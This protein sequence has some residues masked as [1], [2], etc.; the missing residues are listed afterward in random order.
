MTIGK[1]TAPSPFAPGAKLLIP[2]FLAVVLVIVY[3]PVLTSDFVNYDDPTYVTA[4]S[5]VRQGIRLGAIL[6][7][8][9][10]TVGGFWQ[11]VTVLS[12][13]LDATLFG[14]NPAG[15]HLTSLLIHILNIL[16]LF[17]LLT[18]LTGSAWRSGLV[19]AL[20]ALHPLNVETVAWVAERKSLLCMLFWLLCLHSYLGYTRTF[21]IGRYLLTFLFFI[22]SLMSKPMGITIPFTMLL[23]DYWPLRR[24]AR[25][26]QGYTDN[27]RWMVLEKLPFFSLSVAFVFLTMA[28]QKSNG[29]ILPS[30]H[31]PYVLLTHVVFNYARYI[32]KMVNPTHLAVLYPRIAG[33]LSLNEIMLSLVALVLISSL[34]LRGLKDN[35]YLLTG[36]LWFLLTLLPVV[37]FVTVGYFDIAD[38]FAYVPLI[39]LFIALSWGLG[40]LIRESKR[41]SY[42]TAAI[43]LGL[44]LL[45]GFLT[46]IQAGYWKNGYTLFDHA[47]QTTRGNY[48][49]HENL[50]RELIAMGRF[51]EAI[52][53]LVESVRIMPAYPNARINLGLTLYKTGRRADGI[54]VLTETA[55]LFPQSAEIQCDL[56]VMLAGEG[57]KE[58]AIRHLTE[59]VRLDPRQA[60]AHYHLGLLYFESRQLEKAAIHLQTATDLEPQSVQTRKIYAEVLRR[61]GKIRESL[62]QLHQAEGL[63]P[64]K[65]PQ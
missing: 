2:F 58:E 28:T 42:A 27:L 51:E 45:L 33:A 64:E 61:Q 6:Q 10:V 8:F 31:S 43:G 59:A 23:L 3:R 54:Q 13:M 5:L 55:Q 32:D 37:G 25:P 63:A 24:L 22:L 36:W 39:G 34:V 21:K 9:T 26:G 47:V 44:C 53:H 35:P 62:A 48:I 41:L 50:G 29:A 20:F 7:A 14:M 18:R 65:P 11:P 46:R 49:M 15:H 38:R 17:S 30:P 56:G 4:N 12:H 57:K 1:S 40:D 60:K 19:A 52:T 16:L